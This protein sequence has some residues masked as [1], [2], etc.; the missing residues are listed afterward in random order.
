MSTIISTFLSIVL[1]LALAAGTGAANSQAHLELR[2]DAEGN[3]S[4][5][6]DAKNSGLGIA[7]NAKLNGLG[8][9]QPEE[10]T[11]PTPGISLTPTST[12]SPISTPTLV[13]GENSGQE[14]EK[15]IE[16]G[17]GA[18]I[19]V[20]AKSDLEAEVGGPVNDNASENHGKAVSTEAK[21]ESTN[22][23]QLKVPTL[24]INLGLGL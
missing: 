10:V 6:P 11:P 3:N 17:I 19:S 22:N 24:N 7:A 14:E 23:I 4:V 2:S 1:T 9:L 12:P 5:N 15:N 13:P 8:S 21:T 18:N 16:A 20:T